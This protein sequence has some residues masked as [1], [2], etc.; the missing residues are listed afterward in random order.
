MA[1]VKLFKK[2]EEVNFDVSTFKEK[3]LRIAQCLL[4]CRE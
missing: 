2:L 1:F 4:F 3:T